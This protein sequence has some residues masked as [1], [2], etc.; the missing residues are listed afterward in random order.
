MVVKIVLVL[1]FGVK[2]A[3]VSLVGE[4]AGQETQSV[5]S[6]QITYTAIIPSMLR[7][8]VYTRSHSY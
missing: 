6:R 3:A 7:S 8:K 1:T 4:D 5:K 2:V